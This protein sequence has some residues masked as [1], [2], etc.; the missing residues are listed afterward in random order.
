MKILHTS[1]WHLGQHFMGKTRH[2]EH[3]QLIDWMVSL[4][5][6]EQIELVI[7]AGD[8]F[9]TGA[10]PSYA[11]EL[12][13][14]LVVSLFNVKCQL[15]ILAGNHDSVSMLN[16]SK[17]LLSY[18]NANV[19]TVPVL[20]LE[21]RLDNVLMMKNASGEP[22]AI[23][24]AVPFL[25]P[26]DL[27]QSFEGESEQ[28]KKDKL[29]SHIAAYY[30]KQFDQALRLREGLDLAEG[31]A[32][33]IIGTG[34]LTVVGGDATESVRDIYVGS[35]DNVPGSTFPEFDYL[36]LGHIHRPQ[37]VGREGRIRYCG[38]PIP[39]SFD[40]VSHIKQVVVF[41]STDI[42]NTLREVA[43]PRFQPMMSIKGS[44]AEVTEAITTETFDGD[45]PTWLEIKVE[46]LEF[47]ADVQNR[48]NDL[49]E[50]KNAELLR[51]TRVK[52]LNTLQQDVANNETLDELSVTDVFERLIDEVDGV[53][54][55]QKRV[56]RVLFAELLSE[57]NTDKG[58]EK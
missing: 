46:S 36:A 8:V 15:L 51:L 50:G 58:A 25:R 34:H 55:E 28:F 35:V 21:E 4:V 23:V 26:K 10:P 16:E 29:L 42:A 11:R 41:E 57:M 54:D 9:D 5:E 24:C 13:H 1:D 43:V 52:P 22:A 38:S 27:Y 48:I 30:Q 44:Y 2:E 49:L 37:K 47:G 45:K 14:S 17:S 3:R 56:Q 53:D 33:P 18:M 19:V 20:E 40:E 32:V 6:V 7:L 12:Y 31:Q 39:L